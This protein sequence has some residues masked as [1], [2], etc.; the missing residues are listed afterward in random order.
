MGVGVMPFAGGLAEQPAG[1][2][3][4]FQ[5]LAHIEAMHRKLVEGDERLN[6]EVRTQAEAV[7]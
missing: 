4:C 3:A 2:I 7:T 6:A 1:L 5:H